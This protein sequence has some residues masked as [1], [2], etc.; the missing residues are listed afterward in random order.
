MVCKIFGLA[1][2][3]HLFLISAIIVNN[4]IRCKTFQLPAAIDAELTS[5]HLPVNEIQLVQ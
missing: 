3:N 4:N 1:S 2:V 5:V